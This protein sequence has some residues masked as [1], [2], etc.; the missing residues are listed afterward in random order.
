MGR[1]VSIGSAV[2]FVWAGL[3]SPLAAKEGF[4]R[5]PIA[6]AMILYDV[7]TTGTSAGLKTHT[8]GVSRLVFDQWGAREIREEDV[9]EVQT[10][11][12]NETRNRHTLSLIDQGTVYSVDYDEKVIYKTRDR[13]MDMAIA[14]GKDLTEENFTFLH[15]IKAIR[16]GTR[17]VAGLTC[18]LWKA[19]GQEVCLYQ[20]IPLAITID[21]DGFH[22]QRTAVHALINKPVSESEFTLPSFPII[23]DEEYTTNA[24]AQT[25]TE[26]YLE[27][28][29]D[30]QE[31][32]KGMAIDWRE[33]NHTLTPEQEKAVIN[34]L[35]QRYLQKQKRLLPKLE[36][37]IVAAKACI[38][39]ANTS[40]AARACIDP[41]N[42]IDEELGDQTENF[43]YEPWDAT[44]RE[45]I[46]RSLE[47]EHQYLKVT[48]QCVRDH[49]KTTEVI[50]CTEGALNLSEQ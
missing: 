43:V 18:D 20:G 10:G 15:D 5:F 41:I 25:R 30:L 50:A 47:G 7:N 39:D 16:T 33:G 3:I 37:A 35:G 28:V 45:T 19:K 13:D 12:F 23:V 21:A 2:M 22:S 34:V 1:V 46:L 8:V 4:K 9:T 40:A 11:D 44:R 36:E 42:R 17:T 38:R 29:D 31:A 27:A 14:Q 24:S 26:D 6:S 48:L 49:N 32:M